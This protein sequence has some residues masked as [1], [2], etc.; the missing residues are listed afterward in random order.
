M[1]EFNSTQIAETNVKDNI[2]QLENDS[3]K[4]AKANGGRLTVQEKSKVILARMAVILAID[5]LGT[6]FLLALNR[7]AN[8]EI[9]FYIYCLRDHVISY[10]FAGIAL[11]SIIGIVWTAV[12]KIDISSWYIT[13][14]MVLGISIFGALSTY[15]WVNFM[16]ATMVVLTAMLIVSVL[17]F[18]YNLF[19]RIFYK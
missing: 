8:F 14:A 3:E 9:S 12:A 7:E 17:Y 19:L 11:L 15:F 6:V 18:V 5:V 4:P 13:P 2:E 10:V 16:P 1:T